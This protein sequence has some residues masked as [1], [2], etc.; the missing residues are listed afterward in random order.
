[1]GD[2]NRLDRRGFVRRVGA[3][4]AG[5]VGV[6]H[7]GAARPSASEAERDAAEQDTDGGVTRFQMV[8]P[9]IDL[10][11]TTYVNLAIV[12][13]WPTEPGERPPSACL[14]E[15]EDR[16]EAYEAAV[17]DLT[18]SSILGGDGNTVGKVTWTRA[19]AARPLKPGM[20]Y[21]VVGGT[22]CDGHVRVTVHDLADEFEISVDANETG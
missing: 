12:A 1:M 6:S 22:P 15:G 8:L 20:A 3:A 5:T 16:L 13:G 4:A 11:E 19:Y 17:V 10:L 7:A 2:D 18:E 14:P 21:R 9:A